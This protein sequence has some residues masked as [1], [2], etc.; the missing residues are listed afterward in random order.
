MI[1]YAI[2]IF[3]SSLAHSHFGLSEWA[4]RDAVRMSEIWF[5]CP[6]Q[7]RTKMFA[8]LFGDIC[9]STTTTTTMVTMTMEKTTKTFSQKKLIWNYI[10]FYN[11]ILPI[12]CWRKHEV[13]SFVSLLFFGIS[14]SVQFSHYKN[15]YILLFC[16]TKMARITENFPSF[17]RDPHF[18]VFGTFLFSC[19]YLFYPDLA[20]FVCHQC[21]A[22]M[23]YA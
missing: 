7:K 16:Q 11:C 10:R 14:L 12:Q 21:D 13:F 9:C 19:I 23:S 1:M 2:S 20:V 15:I 4:M 5:V 3:I 22:Q 18:C 8:S 6:I 17:S